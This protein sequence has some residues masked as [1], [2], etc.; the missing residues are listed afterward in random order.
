MLSNYKISGTA[1]S[2][3]KS[4]EADAST[5]K[6]NIGFMPGSK[7]IIWI[8]TLLLHSTQFNALISINKLQVQSDQ[9][10]KDI[11]FAVKSGIDALRGYAFDILSTKYF[12]TATAI[13]V[14]QPFIMAGVE[15]L[16]AEFDTDFES[17]IT[18]NINQYIKVLDM[19]SIKNI[20]GVDL[21]QTTLMPAHLL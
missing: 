8:P 4:I 6:I 18:D 19:E 13:M 11:I 17:T 16:Y 20:T 9:G 12:G 5:G 15:S 14:L 2:S 10:M 1:Y 21:N 7:S 3:L